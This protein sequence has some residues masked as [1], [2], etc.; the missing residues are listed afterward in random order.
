MGIE[1]KSKDLA[2]SLY[3]VVPEPTAGLLLV[4]GSLG[5]AAVY[6]RRRG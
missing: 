5:F 3:T 4:C 6:R 1:L 2:F